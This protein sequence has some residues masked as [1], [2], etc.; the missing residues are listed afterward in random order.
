[1]RSTA[2]D[3]RSRAR[4][5][6]SIVRAT[7]VI[8]RGT[9]P[10]RELQTANDMPGPACGCRRL[11][12]KAATRWPF[13]SRTITLLPGM[14][15]I[16]APESAARLAPVN[17]RLPPSAYRRTSLPACLDT[18]FEVVTVG[19][20]IPGLPWLVRRHATFA[21]TGQHRAP[22]CV[23]AAFVAARGVAGTSLRSS[24]R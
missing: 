24:M 2:S 5:T 14:R 18:H 22:V 9:S 20:R 7:L 10:I 6:E 23:E 12:R 3:E 11:R 19:A 8:A 17:L 16:L 13:P 4:G 21:A 1:M 15:A